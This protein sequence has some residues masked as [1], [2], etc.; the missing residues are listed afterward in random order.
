LR[1]RGEPE[2]SGKRKARA[3]VRDKAEEENRMKGGMETGDGNGD[4]ISYLQGERRL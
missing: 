4:I 3:R 2:I 1:R